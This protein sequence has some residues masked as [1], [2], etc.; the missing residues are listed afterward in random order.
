MVNEK[1]KKAAEHIIE[2]R[3]GAFYYQDVN[4]LAKYLANVLGIDPQKA[5]Q[6]ANSIEEDRTGAN[7]Y[8]DVEILAEFLDG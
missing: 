6:K 7:Y 4:V 3:H 2:D 8:E 1:C 5:L